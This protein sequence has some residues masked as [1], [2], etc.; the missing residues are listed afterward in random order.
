[1]MKG[2]TLLILILLHLVDGFTECSSTSKIRNTENQE[3]LGTRVGSSPAWIWWAALSLKAFPP[4][5]KESPFIF[6]HSAS[7]YFTSYY[8]WLR[9]FWSSSL[10]MPK[11]FNPCCCFFHPISNLTGIPLLLQCWII[12]E[13]SRRY[14]ELLICCDNFPQLGQ[15][16]MVKAAFTTATNFL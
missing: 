15:L 9:L 4:G 6:Y 10:I 3:C 12:M 1:M 5:T 16:V 7:G 2:Q 14:R 8:S 13:L 11:I